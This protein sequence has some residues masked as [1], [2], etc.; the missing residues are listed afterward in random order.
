MSDSQLLR[1]L[2]GPIGPEL[3]C[4]ECFDNLDR[5]VETEL[6]DGTAAAEVRVPGMQQ[7]LKG[8][9]A[10]V[11]DHASLLAYTAE[12]ADGDPSPVSPLQPE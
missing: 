8:C 12:V 3:T 6:V 1:V 4:E 7:H 5:Y 9:P 11:E 2:L 10:C